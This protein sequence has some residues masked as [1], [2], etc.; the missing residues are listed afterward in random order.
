MPAP[1]GSTF[2]GNAQAVH[3]TTV[4]YRPGLSD[5][6]GGALQDDP[7][8]PPDPQTMPTSGLLNT[9]SAESVSYGKAVACAGIGINAGATPT[10]AFFWTAANLIASNP[11]TVTRN[12]AG[13]YSITFAAN[14]L[15]ITGWPKPYLNALIGAT[16]CSIAAVNIT[17]GVRVQV[18]QG[19]ALTD[20]DF[21]VD[22]F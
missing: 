12:A 8:N 19:G 10:V 9:L 6:N 1:N 3:P 5:F 18:T 15:P 13:D 17:N 2:D 20:L 14:L 21:S 11:F 16:S 7:V 22:F 4:G